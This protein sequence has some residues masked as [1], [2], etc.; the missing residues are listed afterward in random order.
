[1]KI[2]DSNL[3][4]SATDL[5]N[6][7][8][9]A[10]LTQL[11]I[12]KAKGELKKPVRKN[13]FLNRIKER[14]EIHEEE[15]LKFLQSDPEKTIVEFDR[16]DSKAQEKTLHAMKEGVDVIA[17]GGL[18]N[19]EYGGR[20][21]FLIKVS[22]H[23]PAFGTWSY[24][25]ADTK[26]TQTT[27]A[28][29]ILQLCVYSD[30][31]TEV[32]G[33]APENMYVVMPDDNENAPLQTEAHRFDDY[34]AYYRLAKAQLSDVVGKELNEASYPEPV[35]HC[36]ICQW[37]PDCDKQ[38]RADDHLTF[39]AGIQKSHIKE[40]KQ[41]DIKTLTQFAITDA[42]T[43]QQAQLGSADAILRT[44]QQAKIQ[45]KGIESGEP[46]FEFLDVI[47]PDERNAQLRGFLKLPEPCKEG[48]LFFD[49]ESARHAPGGGLE[50][51]LGFAHGETDG[52]DKLDFDYFWGLDRQG[53]KKAFEA[54]IDLAM[55]KLKQHPDMHIYHFAPYEPVAMKRLA[56]RHATREIELDILLRKQCFVDLYSITRQ[57][58]R[59][60]VES[61][62]IKC[63]E[64]FYGYHREEALAEARLS[65]HRVEEMLEIGAIKSIR[66]EDQ[67]VVLKYNRDDC[68]S[69]VALRNWL[70]TLRQDQ[71]N[72]GIELPR[73]P[74]PEDYTP[75]A[76]E[77]SAEVAKVFN[78]LTDG[79][80]EL[81][82]TER[83][84]HQNAKW[85][86]AHCL[87]YFRREEKNAWW[88]YY[89]LRE[90]DEPDLIKE[91]N[92]L[93]GLTFVEERPKIGKER[94]VTHRYKYI[95]Q[96]VT[97][98]EGNKLYEASSE[99]AAPKEFEI[100]AVVAIDHHQNTID[101]KKTGSAKDKHP[102]AVFH[103][104][105]ISGKPMPDTLLQLGEMIANTKNPEELQI[106][107]YDLLAKVSP[108]F[109]NGISIASALKQFKD[110]TDS[111]YELISNLDNSILAIQGPPGTGKTYTGSHIISHLLKA[112]HTIGIT[113]VSHAVISNL[114]ANV[115][116]TD[117]SVTIAHRAGKTDTTTNNCELL[118]S[119]KD[120]IKAALD[121][122]WVVGAT[123]WTWAA[124]EMEK[125]LDYLFIDEAGQ[126]SLAMALAA[127]RA[128]KNVILL[129]D[130]QQLEQPQKADHPEGS[131]VAALAHL[132]GDQQTIS[133]EQGLFLSTTYRM[134][135]DIC[136]FTSKQY[137]EHKL[138]AK[139]GLEQ[140]VITGSSSHAN[141]QLVF[142]PVPHSGNQNRSEEECQAIKSL[143]DELLSKPHHWVDSHNKKHKLQAEHILVV[144]PYNA[145]VALLQ[146][147]LLEGVRVGTVDKFQGQ[148]APIVI[149]SMT[150]SSVE[151][152]PRGMSF[153]FSPNRFNVAT[154]RAKCSVFV[155]GSPA[156]IMA[157][158]KTPEQIKWA[159]GLCRFIELA[160]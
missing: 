114:L 150:S 19:D 61:Y 126:M 43:L 72:N 68:I 144:A 65:M 21:D 39:V 84:S 109:K 22:T 28:G 142:K 4:L 45:H 9:C 42:A 1:M 146:Q 95:D 60:S 75:Q 80:V 54:F 107:Q 121:E 158:C 78:A 57:S 157:E 73:P 5:S 38:R 77:Q 138:K 113:A 10:H 92:A 30:L 86:L 151:D 90:L 76:D 137:Y 11:E 106:S 127:A 105:S 89:R 83:D 131:E 44:H 67:D 36:D 40:L 59:A 134:H 85:L 159:N 118:P 46:E 12:R 63:L 7:L 100:G 148:Q 48:D 25:V 34:K 101:I 141:S 32:Q 111:T 15:F 64:Q 37:W 125:Q 91:R 139:P 41:H 82:A 145:Q 94:N 69:T 155:F 154:S 24:E 122:G 132:I 17:Q 81:P 27:K 8:S 2:V 56:T 140:Q 104:T 50:Y 26:L 47:Y 110:P 103:H 66:K 98:G 79:L 99:D 129:G 53:E 51:L 143:I 6:H 147:R 49:I 115:L 62:S 136:K 33:V 133:N 123:A 117:N 31:I 149:Y 116:E 128:A 55:H 124:P 71:I 93:T 135:P 20:P 35:T 97:L 29:T 130:P 16:E 160:S 156:L 87:E 18:G 88:E 13:H 108:R 70:E 96:F 23:S 102:N 74:T 119:S 152:A 120:K 14:G 112:G 3:H 58:I 153:L 52:L